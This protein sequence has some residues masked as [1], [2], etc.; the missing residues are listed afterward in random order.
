MGWIRKL[1]SKTR[2]AF[3]SRAE[4]WSSGWGHLGAIGN[5]PVRV[6]G[7][8]L[9]LTKESQKEATTKGEKGLEPSLHISCANQS[10][11]K[12]SETW[13]GVVEFVEQ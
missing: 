1:A 11:H 9:V 5:D 10:F 4:V 12:V 3:R 2:G 8:N 6:L 13:Q 7:R